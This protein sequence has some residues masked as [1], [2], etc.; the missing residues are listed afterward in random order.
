M[1]DFTR[2]DPRNFGVAERKHEVIIWR[3][4][5]ND[6]LRGCTP[7]QIIAHDS[8]SLFGFGLT[9]LAR[10]TIHH[11]AS[12]CRLLAFLMEVSQKKSAC[13]QSL[14]F[15]LISDESK[16]NDKTPAARVYGFL[17]ISILSLI[18]RKIWPASFNHGYIIS[19][20]HLVKE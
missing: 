19:M 6:K 11:A 4:E 14:S 18:K 17:H 7:R 9:A 3:G 16:P 2:F 20:F 8:C 1:K 5:R 12:F 13:G 15:F 10:S